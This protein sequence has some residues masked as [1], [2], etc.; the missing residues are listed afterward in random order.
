MRNGSSERGRDL[1][2]IT[3]TVSDRAGIG[4]QVIWDPRA[5]V[6]SGL[7]LMASLFSFGL[8]F[9]VIYGTLSMCHAPKVQRGTKQTWSL[10]SQPH[11][12]VGS[13]ARKNNYEHYSCH[14]R[15]GQSPVGL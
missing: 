6:L 12:L 3:Q 8:S 14:Q 4:I 1:P 11:R 9:K 5:Y 10:P 7:L 15:A 13:E 2:M